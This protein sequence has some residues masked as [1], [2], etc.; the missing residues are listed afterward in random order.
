M[1]EQQAII[2]PVAIVRCPQCQAAR[3]LTIHTQSMPT[4]HATKRW[5]ECRQC[6]GTFTVVYRH[7]EATSQI[8]KVATSPAG[9]SRASSSEALPA[10][11]PRLR[12]TA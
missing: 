2:V 10:T 11:P 1:S 3:P 5:H 6:G 9:A 8:W 12:I 7:V 4:A